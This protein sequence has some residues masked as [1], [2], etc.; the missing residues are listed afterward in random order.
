MLD[1]RQLIHSIL[2][3]DQERKKNYHCFRYCFQKTSK[4]NDEKS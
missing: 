1:D 3:S 2:V 4:K